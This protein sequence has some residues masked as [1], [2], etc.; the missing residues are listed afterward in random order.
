MPLRAAFW[1]QLT[2]WPFLAAVGISLF[3]AALRIHPLG[4][5]LWL[6]EL[7][8]AWCAV[9]PLDE[10]AR[11]AAMGN[12][13]PLF[14]WLEW[15]ALGILG[16][17]ELS[18][19]LVSLVSGSLLP[20]AIFLFARRWKLEAAGLI[21][22][23]LIAV[24]PLSIFYATEARPYA[25]LQLLAIAHVALTAELTSR[26]TRRLR[27]A[28]IGVGV[29]MFWLH[30]TAGLI[31]L[32]DGVFLLVARV[33]SPPE[34]RTSVVG[35]LVDLALVGLLCLPQ[36]ATVHAVFAHRANWAAFISR[37]P[38][39][40]AIEWFPLPA[41]WWAGLVVIG[42]VGIGW[43][44]KAGHDNRS[45]SG[46]RVGLLALAWLLIPITCA[47]LATWTDTARLFYPRYLIAVLPAAS[48]L[49]GFCIQAIDWPWLR[50]AVGV[51]T[52]ACAVWSGGIA[53]R[54]AHEGTVIEPRG[55]DWRGAVAWLN[56]R[57]ADGGYPVLVS[58]GLIE[59]DE[60]LQPHDELLEDY[61]L[62]PVNSLYPLDI[63]RGDMFPLPLHEPRGIV[64]VAEMLVV[65][66]GGAWLIVRGDERNASRVAENVITHLTRGAVPGAN[67]K[68]RL[69]DSQSFGKVQV[70]LLSAN[71]NEQGNR[72]DPSVASP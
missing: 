34:K 63:D 52:I 16:P 19:R 11:R 69:A 5:S 31:V 65:H 26:S 40:T 3:A 64:E 35:V 44:M 12:Q 59:A 18:L 17:S 43:T 42:L 61:C 32:A 14:F 1:K 66:C 30:Y 53:E 10:V 57:L 6:D 45:V 50:A 23:G 9:G 2:D 27:F 62:A 25:A 7:H 13:G 36:L 38:I 58:S 28:W 8:T 22:A 51:L 24:D 60:L 70:R 46:A 39:W 37:E 21:A 47:W 54:I 29:V 20:L 71:A 67:M 15:L 55:E 48:L 72:G 4:E 56:D 41:W 33:V 49:A 68:W